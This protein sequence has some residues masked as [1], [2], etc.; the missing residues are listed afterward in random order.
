M[1]QGKLLWKYSNAFSKEQKMNICQEDMKQLCFGF[2]H[3]DYETCEVNNVLFLQDYWRY[4]QDNERI[5]TKT[6]TETPRLAN[7]GN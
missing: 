5:K 3:K 6:S 1:L 4:E 7:D 2:I